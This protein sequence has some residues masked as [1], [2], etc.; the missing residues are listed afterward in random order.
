MAIKQPSDKSYFILPDLGEGVHEAELIKWRVK[1][2]DQV[3]EHQT[4]AEMET[5]KALVEVPSPWAGTI[6][7]LHGD[8]GD[9][10]NVGSKLVSYATSAGAAAPATTA[11]AAGAG[12]A[13]AGADGTSDDA[14]TVVGTVAGELTVSDRFR[15]RAPETAAAATGAKALA[16]PAVRRIAREL[17]VDINRVPGSGRGGRVT[18]SDVEAFAGGR[19]PAAPAA[20]GA[21][22]AAPAPAAPAVTISPDGVAQRIPFRGVRRKIAQSLQRSVHTAVHFTVVDEADVTRLEQKRSEYMAVLGRKL[23]VLPFIMTAVCHAL[24]EHPSLNANVDDERE[25]ILVKDVINLGCAVD[26]D[27]GLMVPVLPNADRMS[28]V[29]LADTVKSLAVACRNRTVERDRLVGGTFTISNVGS[30][31]GLFATPI[32][33]YPEVAILAIG[34]GTEKVLT[35]GGQFYAGKVLP[36]SLSCDHRVVDGAEG[37]RF[38][39]T[40]RRYLESPDRLLQGR[41]IQ[42]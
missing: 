20:A 27:H 41:G 22:P 18:A 38:V 11:V 29:Q 33:N 4:L 2:G 34:R 15:R 40:V 28:I 26:T 39:N 7:E 21:P 32:I 35:H 31:G 5:D 37:A 17:G 36:L 30:Y 16:T 8:E 13:A 25:E 23:S 9:I 42:S 10:L 1:P 12:V 3:E 19:A 14:G 24:R 6:A